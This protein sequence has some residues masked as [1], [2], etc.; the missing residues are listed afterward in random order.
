MASHQ[1]SIACRTTPSEAVTVVA[2]IYAADGELHHTVISGSKPRS[3]SFP[4][5]GVYIIYQNRALQIAAPSCDRRQCNHSHICR[6]G[7]NP[8]I[9]SPLSCHVKQTSV[10][11]PRKPCWDCL[12]NWLHLY[13][14]A[15]R[16][17]ALGLQFLRFPRTLTG[18]TILGDDAFY[19]DMDLE[20]QHVRS[21]HNG[22]PS[23]STHTSSRRSTTFQWIQDTWKEFL[24]KGSYKPEKVIALA[25]DADGDSE[26]EP[27]DYCTDIDPHDG[28][29]SDSDWDDFDIPCRPAKRAKRH[30][31]AGADIDADFDLID[32]LI[33]EEF[34]RLRK[35]TNTARAT[36]PPSRTEMA[37]A[38]TDDNDDLLPAPPVIVPPKG[39]AVGRALSRPILVPSPSSTSLRQSSL[40]VVVASSSRCAK[41]RVPSKGR[42]HDL[43]ARA[44]VSKHWSRR[45]RRAEFGAVDF[46]EGLETPASKQTTLKAASDYWGS[47][48]CGNILGNLLIGWFP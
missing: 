42:W 18:A 15:D 28:A 32:D 24:D 34:P 13:A 1:G 41:P 19:Y 22:G 29:A 20:D 21:M 35:H 45:P 27:M 25:S 48:Q 16:S 17:H 8:A 23:T 7:V 46:V 38:G 37:G 14:A 47:V 43:W 30:D 31:S 39:M 33:E 11:S 10:P 36:R 3:P 6:C 9:N 26:V 40:S 4:S 5:E 44:R 12:V 2:V